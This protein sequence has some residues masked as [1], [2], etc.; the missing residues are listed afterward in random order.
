MAIYTIP[1][2]YTGYL[3]NFDIHVDPTNATTITLKIKTKNNGEVWRTRYVSILNDSTPSEHHEYG[4]P[5]EINPES[6][7]RMEV[8]S[9]ANNIPISST[10]DLRLDKNI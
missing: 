1:R 8:T 7:I 5:L 10:F 9:T 3:H 2:G 4:I 6:D